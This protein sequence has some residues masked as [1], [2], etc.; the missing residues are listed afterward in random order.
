MLEV[1][2]H[3]RGGQGAVTASRILATAFV[4]TGRYGAS[5]PMFGF[6]RRGAPVVAYGRFDEEPIRVKTAIYNPDVLVVLD[7][8]QWDS[9][10]VWEGLNS[11]GTLILNAQTPLEELKNE[12]LKKAC[13]VDANGIALDEIG[14]AMP[15]TCILGA[16]AAATGLI[17]LD[18]IV[19][20][21]EDYFEGNRLDGNVRCV[22]RG[23]EENKIKQF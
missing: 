10:A 2:F 6:E 20:G 17:D 7:P 19:V 5:F 15:N 9:P 18:S 1:R 11:G 22:R 23:F 3:G 16:F 4:N 12:N 8:A 14:I 13:F 21:L